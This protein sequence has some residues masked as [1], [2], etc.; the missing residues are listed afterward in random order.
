MCARK[1]GRIQVELKLTVPEKAENEN[2]DQS[3][4]ANVYNPIN[5][6]L[7]PQQSY[8]YA[9]YQNYSMFNSRPRGRFNQWKPR[10]NCVIL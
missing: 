7:M 10:R 8:R 3:P 5:P 6:F 1:K 4:L 2:T 9:P